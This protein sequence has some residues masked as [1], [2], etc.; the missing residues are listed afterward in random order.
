VTQPNISAQ[1]DSRL[2]EVSTDIFEAIVQ[3]AGEDSIVV[4][5]KNQTSKFADYIYD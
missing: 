1:S 4:P 2:P 5:K 3:E